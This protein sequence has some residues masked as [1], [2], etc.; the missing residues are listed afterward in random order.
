MN[1]FEIAKNSDEFAIELSALLDLPLSLDIERFHVSG[2]LCSLAFEYWHGTRSLVL[3]NFLPCAATTLRSQFE[4]ILRSIWVL[5]VASNDQIEKLS[6]NLCADSEN[7]AKKI[8]L[9][10]DM[11]IAL[12]KGG[13]KNAY[14]A[15]IRFKNNSWGALNSFVHSG[16]HAVYRHKEGYPEEILVNL[17]KN[18]NG[19]AVISAMHFAILSG[20]QPMQKDIIDLAGKRPHCMPDPIAL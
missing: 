14:D 8:P 19:L 4:S 13:D 3:N 11:L 7:A 20:N 16:I 17:L 6:D 9:A 5:Y 15:L 18:S 2:V 1:I 12:S 10:N